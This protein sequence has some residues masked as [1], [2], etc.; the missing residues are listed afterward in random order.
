M[1]VFIVLIEVLV[2]MAGI[3]LVASAQNL[4][5]AGGGFVLVAGSLIALTTAVLH[6]RVSK[7][8]AKH[9]RPTSQRS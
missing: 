9:S 3:A 7:H 1:K 6:L 2:L 4:I 8:P 5:V